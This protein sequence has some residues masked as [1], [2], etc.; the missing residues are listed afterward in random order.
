M[1]IPGLITVS[2]IEAQ[3][4]AKSASASAYE[5]GVA[6]MTAGDSAKAQSELEAALR[7][8]PANADAQ[9]ALGKVLLYKS[10]LGRAVTHLRTA[11]KLKPNSGEAHLDLGQALAASG[12]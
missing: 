12:Q 4:S 8:N 1:V 10:D 5:R 11:T 7:A 9:L 6:A 2:A 3:S